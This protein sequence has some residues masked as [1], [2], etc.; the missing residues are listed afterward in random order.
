M[1]HFK[2]S[3]I[4]NHENIAINTVD[5]EVWVGYSATS[6]HYKNNYDKIHLDTTYYEWNVTRKG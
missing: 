4:E 6:H 1:S 2:F 5:Y 3:T